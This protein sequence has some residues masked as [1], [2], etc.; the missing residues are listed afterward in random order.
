MNGAFLVDILLWFIVLLFSLSFHESAH[1]LVSDRCGDNTARLLGRISLNPLV[2]IDPLGT[3]IFPLLSA[4]TGIPLF[5]WAK[6]TPVN[7]LNW[8]DKD[9]AN[10]LVS[11]AG[12]I[13]NLIL[14]VLFFGILKGLLMGGIVF[15]NPLARQY[16]D[17]F[18]GEGVI[19]PIAKILWIAVFTNVALAVFNL[20]PIPPLD[21]SHIVE[22]LLPPEAA[23]GYE[24]IS[25][26]P[27]SIILFYGLLAL[28]V[29]SAVLTPVITFVLRLLMM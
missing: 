4:V 15:E 12:P 11:A 29:F 17:I 6:P 10:I 3:V 16:F 25:R 20:F 14:A 27:F 21:G 7:P 23:R 26:F 13:S 24:Q 28:G 22:S 5:G 8:R 9:R 1:A 18:T 19:E 2:H